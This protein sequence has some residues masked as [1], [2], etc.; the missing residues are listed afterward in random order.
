MVKTWTVAPSLV[1][2]Y[3]SLFTVPAQAGL[4][5]SADE[6]PWEKP[7][8]TGSAQL[9]QDTEA[10]PLDVPLHPGAAQWFREQ[11]HAV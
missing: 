1:V 5:A 2:P 9:G 4:A 8:Y 11:G 6:I 3:T 7:A 10:T